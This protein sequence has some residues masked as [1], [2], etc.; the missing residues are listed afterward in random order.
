M[1]RLRHHE[2]WNTH[3]FHL[4]IYLYWLYLSIKAR[5][6]FFFSAANPGIEN[7]GLMGE[8]KYR[9]LKKI[10]DRF[11]PPTIYFQG[12]L[13][14][15]QMIDRLME[16]G[17][18]FPFVVKPDIGQGGWMIGKIEDREDLN[19]FLNNIRMPFIVQEFVD[20]PMEFGLLYYRFPDSAKGVISSLSMKELLSV[21]GDGHHTIFQ[22]LGKIPRGKKQLQRLLTD[23]RMNLARIPSKG[24]K[25]QLSF[26]GNHSYGTTFRNANALID[27]KLTEV[28][29]RLCA[30]IEGFYFGRFDIRCKSLDDVREGRFRILE[31]NGVGSE[32]LHIFD[33]DEKLL[34]AWKSSFSHWKT[35][36]E[37]AM[38]NNRKLS[39]FMKLSQA[40]ETYKN[41]VRIQRI[42]QTNLTIGN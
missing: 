27:S 24:E 13:P 37:I 12:P 25:V 18:N 19:K 11:V 15:E 23:R 16:T 5:S 9:I 28:F 4:P 6:L 35:I 3:L 10:D 41:V 21:E 36:Y 2:F 29:D 31:L 40:W 39:S 8:S 14:G 32:P 7:G 1:L 30:T 42:H 33:P 34:R 22:L 20:E 26:V 17:I 38:V